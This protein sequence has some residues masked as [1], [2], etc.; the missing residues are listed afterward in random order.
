[1]AYDYSR[2]V[3]SAQAKIADKGRTVSFGKVASGAIDAA[4]P[5][6]APTDI[7]PDPVTTM[8]VFV[9]VSSVAQFGFN[10][11]ATG[12]FKNAQKALLVAAD[13]VN[14]YL[15]FDTVTDT[16][17]SVWKVVAATALQPGDT[18]ILYAIGVSAP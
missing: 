10:V 5:L 11:T 16:D 1:M 15:T 7:A 17:G 9:E 6:A 3:K 8:A 2:A 12:L 14:D 4:N 13:G 18:V